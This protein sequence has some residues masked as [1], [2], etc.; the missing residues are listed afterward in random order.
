MKKKNTEEK[1]KQNNKNRSHFAAKKKK[2]KFAVKDSIQKE[3]LQKAKKSITIQIHK[4][5][6]LSSIFND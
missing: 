6:Q 5:T 2:L 3:M 4:P 1:K